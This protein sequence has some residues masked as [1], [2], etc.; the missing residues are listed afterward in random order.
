MITRHFIITGLVQGVCYRASL[1]AEAR[2]LGLDGWVRNRRDSSVEAVAR[3]PEAALAALED[4]ARKGPPGAR[5]SGVET[6]P[7]DGAVE[8]GFR[9]TPSV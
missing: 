1:V 3:G 4:W 6:S 9:Q 7:W 5:V 8:P 2:A